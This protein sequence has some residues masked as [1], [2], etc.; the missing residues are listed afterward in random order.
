MDDGLTVEHAHPQVFDRTLRDI[1]LTIGHSTH[2]IDMF[3]DLLQR[4]RVTAVCDVRS[5]PFSRTNPEFTRESLQRSL[6]IRGVAYVF[7]GQE[8]GARSQD[9]SCYVNGKVAY[10]RLAGTEL[11]QTGLNRVRQGIKKHRIALMCAERDPLQCHRT[12]LVSRHLV[13]GGLAVQHI[14][15]DGQLESHQDAMQRLVRRLGLPEHDLFRTTDDLVADAYRIQG[16]RIAYV[17]PARRDKASE[18]ASR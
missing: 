15:G 11:F 14:T 18:G 8:L 10:D 4:H 17:P 13:A 5:T 2:P 16:E 3:L 6:Q 9:P 12:I 7:L 1:V